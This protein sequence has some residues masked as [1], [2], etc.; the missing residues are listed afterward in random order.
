MAHIPYRNFLSYTILSLAL[1]GCGSSTV[2]TPVVDPAVESQALAAGVPLEKKLDLGD[3]VH[4]KLRF[5]PAGT[6]ALGSASNDPSRGVDDLP[7]TSVT[8]EAFYISPCEITQAQYSRIMDRNPS[9]YMGGDLPVNNMSWDDAATFCAKVSEISGENVSLPTEIQW[10]YAC[11]A[12]STGLY[13]FGNDVAKLHEYGWFKDNSETRAHSVG[14]LKPN[15]WSVYDMHGSVWEW[16]K[17]EGGTPTAKDLGNVLR[18]GAWND[19][20]AFCR[21]AT[22]TRPPAGFHNFN[23]GFRVVVSIK[24]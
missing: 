12:G 2:Q 22:R 19:S 8:V 1:Y 14:T 4:L 11:R 21:S 10:E 15:A 7:R 20:A 24:K 9:V 18:G 5:I 6:I 16:C 13:T 23:V 17:S 3:G